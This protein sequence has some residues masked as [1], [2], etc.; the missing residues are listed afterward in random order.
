[1]HC[2][3]AQVL[4][5]VRNWDYGKLMF[6]KNRVSQYWTYWYFDSCKVSVLCIVLSHFNHIQL[7]VTLWTVAHQTRCPWDSIG[8]NTGVASVSFSRGSSR[9][10]DQSWI[11]HISWISRQILYDWATREAH[12]MYYGILFNTPGSKY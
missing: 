1:M 10:R 8:K 7:F 2:S 5:F 6:F 11:S 12:L 4:I 9:S 3:I